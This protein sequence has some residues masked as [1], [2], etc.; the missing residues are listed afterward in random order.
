MS[1]LSK[2]CHVTKGSLTTTLNKLV[3]EGFVERIAVPGDRRVVMVR[4]TLK[5]EDH[6]ER[7][8]QAVIT[9]MSEAFHDMPE[10]KK[11]K[12]IFM[13]LILFGNGMGGAIKS[14][15]ANCKVY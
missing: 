2:L 9:R 8:K 14:L 3:E 6:L 10:V 12:L 11:E 4:L 15:M 7:S 1:D 5:G 13:F